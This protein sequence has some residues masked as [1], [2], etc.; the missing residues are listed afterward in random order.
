MGESRKGEAHQRARQV[1]RNMAIRGI[2]VWPPK[3]AKSVRYVT[4]ASLVE[5][6]LEIKSKVAI[7]SVPTLSVGGPWHWVMQDRSGT[8]MHLPA[9]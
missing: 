1:W 9:P 4:T 8:S 3:G 5:V 2:R 6:H 7:P